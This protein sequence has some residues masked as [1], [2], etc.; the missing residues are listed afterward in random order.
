MSRVPTESDRIAATRRPEASPVMYQ[1]WSDL[2]FLHWEISPDK[3]AA[4]LP[5][6]LHVDT[7]EGN[8]YLGLVPFFMK[9]IRPR[10]LPA[11]GPISNFLEMNVRTYVHDD[12]GRPG[13]WFYSLD[14]SQ[15]LAVFLARKMFHLPY[16]HASMEATKVEGSTH[17]QCHRNGTPDDEMS[18][19]VYRGGEKLS[20]PLPG[21]LEYFLL[22]RYYLFAHRKV[23]NRLFCGQVHHTPYPAEIAGVT[24]SVSPALEQ[25]GFPLDTEA[26]D[27]LHYSPGVK[28]SVYPITPV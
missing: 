28:V 27:L 14:A 8:A 13:V 19:F 18:Q 10:F 5:E 25:A 26:P 22:E 9:A 17:Y 24:R 11:V 15:P 23:G 7:H 16:F 20:P 2:L 21:S 3:I 6:G 1:E 4:T 12:S